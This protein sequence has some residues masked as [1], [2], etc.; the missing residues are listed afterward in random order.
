MVAHAGAMPLDKLAVV[1]VLVSL[2]PP[3]K[4]GS[5]A[6]RE[7][8]TERDREKGRETGGGRHKAT[9][10][11]ALLLQSS[12]TASRSSNYKIFS[13]LVVLPHTSRMCSCRISST[14]LI[15]QHTRKTKTKTRKTKTK[16][17]FLTDLTH[18]DQ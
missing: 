11:S 1:V 12:L 15:P 10:T 6:E 13:N 18:F 14:V 7:G 9:V 5:T 2:V 16:T 17:I 8:Q 4:G 3:E